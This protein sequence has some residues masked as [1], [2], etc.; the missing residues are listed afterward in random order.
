[1]SKKL[2]GVIQKIKQG[3]PEHIQDTTSEQRHGTKANFKIKD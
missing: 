1:M 3:L 2:F